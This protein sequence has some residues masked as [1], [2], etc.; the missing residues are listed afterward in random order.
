MLHLIELLILL[1]TILP[2]FHLLNALFA[3]RAKPGAVG[4]DQEQF[5]SIVIPCYNEE[6]TVETSLSGLLA[7][8]YKNYEAIYINDGSDDGTLAALAL[9]LDLR[10]MPNTTELV[11]VRQVFQSGKYENIWVADK[12][13]GGKG[14][15]LNVGIALARSELIVTVDADSILKGNALA[16][17]NQAFADREVVA[18]A[19]A[20]HITQGYDLEGLGCRP[21][22]LRRLLIFQQI[23]EYLKG[24]Y[25]NKI[26]L[27]RQQAIAIIP[28]AFGVFR[29]DVLKA[30]GGY[31]N[32]LGEDADI[33]M[34]IQQFIGAKT[35]GKI[36]YLPQALCYT[37]CPE[38][39]RD[40]TKQRLRWQKGFVDCL[41]YQKWFLLKTFFRRSVSF[42]F[43]IE[44]GF[45]GFCSGM[46][47]VVSNIFILVYALGNGQHMALTFLAYYGFCAA[48]GAVN[49]ITAIVLSLK[50]NPYPLALL[51]KMGP[52]ILID[53]LLYRYFTLFMYLRGTFSYFWNRSG[54]NCW[55][56]VAR[57]KQRPVFLE[58]VAHG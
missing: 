8:S 38:N 32:S 27:A 9:L 50:Y 6:D 19:G 31:R 42:H 33:T 41:L 55:Y 14:L 44:A 25:I 10:Q 53:I 13:K 21:N 24:F 29:K 49:D 40:L 57:S 22:Y 23:L 54:N 4:L 18:A 16:F 12:E 2:L 28:G 36:L 48:F 45:V 30:V 47:T 37:Q 5:F 39:L 56:K 34:R 3:V 1:S 52:A 43:L 20:I 17:M 7:Q 46:F 35:A 15:A 58:E 51:R 26:S 11:G